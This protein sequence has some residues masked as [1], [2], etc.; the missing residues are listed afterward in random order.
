[1]SLQQINSY[2]E[3][4]IL[5]ENGFMYLFGEI[6]SKSLFQFRHCRYKTRYSRL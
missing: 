4:N 6:N 1:M 2:H 3:R 5:V